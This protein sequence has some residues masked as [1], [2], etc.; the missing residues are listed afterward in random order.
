MENETVIE[1]PVDRDLLTKRYTEKALEFIERTKAGLSF[2]T[3]RRPC[4]AAR[5]RRSPARPS[6]ARAATVRG[7]I[8][9]RN[10]IGRP[11]RCWTSWSKSGHRR[12]DAGDLDVGQRRTDGPRDR[13]SVARHQPTAARPR[14]HDRRR[15]VSRA[16]DHVVAESDSRRNGLRGTRDDDGFAADVCR[17][18]RRQ[19]PARPHHRRPRHP[20]A[21]L[22][23]ARRRNHRTTSSTTTNEDQ[24]QA[25]RS[26]PWKLFS[27][28]GELHQAP[29]FPAAKAG[30]TLLFN[31]VE[32]V[33]SST[34]WR[35]ASRGRA[36]V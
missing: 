16:D 5:E 25:V 8:R 10:S 14:L 3:C 17:A 19:C 4:P 32:D 2:S 9:S 23:R 35:R 15:R 6:K 28:A 7:A 24:L 21:D 18:G 36:S 1:A 29:A 31:V 11:A 13:Q 12:S 27:A 33:G 26:G 20:A 30:H 22:W 34:T